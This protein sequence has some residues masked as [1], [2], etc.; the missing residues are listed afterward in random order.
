MATDKL[1]T[2]IGAHGA[3]STVLNRRSIVA[4]TIQTPE[5]TV[6]ELLQAVEMLDF[7]WFIPVSPSKYRGE[8]R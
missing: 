1:Q 2:I 4:Q 8:S 6:K 5:E 7:L 3:T